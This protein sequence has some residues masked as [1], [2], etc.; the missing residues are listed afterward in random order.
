ML[1]AGKA[2]AVLIYEFIQNGADVDFKV[3]GS[4]SGLPTPFSSFGTVG[5]LAIIPQPGFVDTFGAGGIFDRF[6]I[7]LNSGASIF[8]TGDLTNLSSYSRKKTRLPGSSSRFDIDSYF[9][10]API[11]GTGVFSGTVLSTLGIGP[12][13]LLSRFAIGSDFIEIYSVPAPQPSSVPGPLPL[14]GAAAAFAHSRRLRARLR[15]S[16]SPQA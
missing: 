6:A 8:G 2:N 5:H 16:A 13:G 1:T 11:A 15:A 4:L 14:F 7:S 9:E 3:S 10:G 12:T